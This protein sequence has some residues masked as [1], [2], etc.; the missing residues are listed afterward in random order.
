MTGAWQQAQL[1]ARKLAPAPHLTVSVARTRSCAFC[2]C[3]LLLAP[4]AWSTRAGSR[5]GPAGGD[6]SR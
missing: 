2:A 3:L 6:L 1:T 4:Q 5:S